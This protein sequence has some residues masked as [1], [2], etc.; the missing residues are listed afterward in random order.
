M[1]KEFLAD[2]INALIILLFLYAA[3]SKI[4]DHS[5]F[6]RAMNN[7]PIPIVFRPVVILLL[8]PVEILTAL[9]IIFKKSRIVGL[10]CFLTLMTIFS[11]YIAFALL[12]LFP[13]M[14]CPCGGLLTKLR[15]PGHLALNIVFIG[16]GFLSLKLTKQHIDI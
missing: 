4:A 7:Q 10:Y 1:K 14:P 13:F 6:V 16:V 3:F 9:L 12:K 11:I 5:A 15:W 2:F 8:P